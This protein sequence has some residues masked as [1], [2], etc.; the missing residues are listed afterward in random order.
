MYVGTY[1]QEWIAYIC[2][3]KQTKVII[4][5]LAN[6]APMY[7]W[8]FWSSTEC[9]SGLPDFYRYSMPKPYH[10]MYQISAKHAKCP[11]DIPKCLM[12]RPSKLYQSWILKCTIWQSWC[13]GIRYEPALWRH[14]TSSMLS[15]LCIRVQ[16]SFL[17]P[18]NRLFR[19]LSSSRVTRF[20]VF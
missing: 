19:F 6:I 3:T 5:N 9:G 16:W 10:K 12:P 15:S 2:S 18:N 8:W 17:C 14:Q 7:A 4:N 13:V 20:G 11:Y 1:D